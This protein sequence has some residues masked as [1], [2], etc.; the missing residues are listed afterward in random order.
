MS[1]KEYLLEKFPKIT[2]IDMEYTDFGD[3]IVLKLNG[4]KY[5]YVPLKQ[6]KDSSKKLFTSFKRRFKN[7]QPKA[8]TWLKNNSLLVIGSKVTKTGI[9]RDVMLIKPKKK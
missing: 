6:S 9:G 1:W 4:H 5:G 2:D 3:T 7:N 8:Y